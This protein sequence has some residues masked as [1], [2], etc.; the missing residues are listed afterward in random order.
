M[1]A[2]NVTTLDTRDPQVA[3]VAVTPELAAQWLAMNTR[4]R[5]LRKPDVAAYARDMLNQDWHLNGE[6][7]KFTPDG[8][9]LDGQHRLQAVIQAGVSVPMLVVRG[10]CEAA[11]PTIDTGITRKFSD[12]LTI[13]GVANSKTLAAL[14][15]RAVR[16]EAGQ[17][18]ST[19][20]Q[21]STSAEMLE[22]LHTHPEIRDAAQF[23]D[24]YASR[25][26][27]P[28]SVLGMAY[29]LFASLDRD[30]A[31]RFLLHVVHEDVPV[32]H[33]AR[34]LNRRVVAMR[35]TQGRVNA[36]EALALTIRGWNAYRTGEE[37]TKLQ[38]PR[39][40]LNST[41]YPEPR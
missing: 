37:R 39:G 19:D 6:S 32:D 41:N 29:W 33:P 22:F 8:A 11:M 4:N 26:L 20:R 14:I 2:P 7:I 16:W 10:V 36:A 25:N 18:Y 1:G 34:V 38:L 40:G 35:I 9:L 31:H 23:G 3:I 15:R 24:Q 13:D 30:Q 28:A 21:R 17:R 27:L 12:V 5:H